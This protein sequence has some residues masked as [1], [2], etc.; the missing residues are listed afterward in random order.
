ML[1]NIFYIFFKRIFYIME[2]YFFF[3]S[4]NKMKRDIYNVHTSI[5]TRK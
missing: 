3:E 2:I 5:P 1:Y 4:K